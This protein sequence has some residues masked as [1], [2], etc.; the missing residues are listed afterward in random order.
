MKIR[1]YTDSAQ[2]ILSLPPQLP[3]SV[4]EA[5]KPYFTYTQVYK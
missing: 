2:T 4:E 5:L 3:L 1:L